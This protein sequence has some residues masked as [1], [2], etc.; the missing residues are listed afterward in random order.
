ME[1]DGDAY[2]Y[3]ITGDASSELKIIEGGPGGKYSSQGSFESS[4]FD[5]GS[6]VA[7][8]YFK[9]NF[10]KPANT[11]IKFQFAGADPVNGSCSQANYIFT[12]PDG[13]L[14]TF[15][16]QEGP[17]Y[18]DDNGSLYENPARCFKYKV[19]FETSELSS[20]PIFS[21]ITINYSP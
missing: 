17:V 6:E 1:A 8:N 15:Y 20:T 18:M 10:V 21:D 11:D 7:F 13:E 4:V 14:G 16:N 5:K 9:A 3:V 12:G 19:F 2:S